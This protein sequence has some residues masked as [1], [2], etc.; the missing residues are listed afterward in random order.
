MSRNISHYI[1]G[2]LLSLTF[3]VVAF[4]L[5]LMHVTS[6]HTALSHTDAAVILSLLALAQ[7]VVQLYFFLHLGE[8]EKPRLNLMVFGY[9]LTLVV[10]LAGGSLWIMYHLQHN[11]H[12]MET[13]N[14]F[15]EEN[16]FPQGHAHH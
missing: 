10:C 1:L 12:P 3:T 7:F 15:K 13:S 8:E 6:G 4:L 14:V 16:I 11:L 2:F 9:A 5:V